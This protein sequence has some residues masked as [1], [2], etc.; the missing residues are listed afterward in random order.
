M[1]F[2]YNRPDPSELVRLRT[3]I[4]GRLNHWIDNLKYQFQSQE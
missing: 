1:L 3:I 4:N 2:I